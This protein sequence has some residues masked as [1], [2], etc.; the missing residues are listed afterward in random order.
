MDL[1][2]SPGGSLFKISRHIGHDNSLEMHSRA[3]SSS[4]AYEPIEQLALSSAFT[5]RAPGTDVM[6]TFDV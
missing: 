2:K 6:D 3:S 1:C 5:L 4:I